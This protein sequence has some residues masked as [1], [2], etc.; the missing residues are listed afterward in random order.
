MVQSAGWA[1]IGT[2]YPFA[3]LLALIWGEG[4]GVGGGGRLLRTLRCCMCKRGFGSLAF[5]DPL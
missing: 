1:H 5:L 2:K 4:W 3:R